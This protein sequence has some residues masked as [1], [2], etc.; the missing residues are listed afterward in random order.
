[1]R[2]L[3]YSRAKSNE[4]HLTVTAPRTIPAGTPL[5]FTVATA[6]LRDQA[7]PAQLAWRAF[8][9]AG[10]VLDRGR[11][12]STGTATV[13]L[14]A[15]LQVPQRIEV[16]AV[17]KGV[18]QSTTFE[19]LPSQ[20]APLVHVR[21]DKPVYRPGEVAWLRGVVLD[22]VTLKPTTQ[23]PRLQFSVLD[24]KGAEVAT[25]WAPDLGAEHGLVAAAQ[26]QV[27]AGA[28][29]GEYRLELRA[30]DRSFPS[31]G[32]PFLVRRFQ[33][34]QLA[35]DVALD[36]KTYAPGE[37]GVAEVTVSRL[38]GG[39]PA[40]AQ[41]RAAL[42]LD[43]TEVWSVDGQLDH[44]GRA[45]FHFQ[46]PEQVERGA[47]RFV[48]R[49]VDGGVV[50]TEVEPF[51]VPTGEVAAALYPESGELVVGIE[52]RV[53]V[54]VTD[55]LGRPV[56]A[57]GEVVDERGDQVA[58]FRSAHQGRGWFLLTPRTGRSYSL[59]LRQPGEH[60]FAIPSARQRG[61]VLRAL[62]NAVPGGSPLRVQAIS[63]VVVAIAVEQTD[64]LLTRIEA[65]AGAVAPRSSQLPSLTRELVGHA[66]DPE[67]IARAARAA[68]LDDVSPID[69]MRST[70]S[71]RRLVLRNVLR[72]LITEL[73]SP[74]PSPSLDE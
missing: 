1:M 22:R 3:W 45:L 52:S 59:R 47:A 43:G 72:T 74:S 49:I 36:R 31:E 32:I 69:D 51:V 62:A 11:V 19:L 61:A 73:T 7:R 34:P 21:T 6:D 41:V 5:G 25:L 63:K 46:V 66:P 50:E 12:Q 38:A 68:A 9:A 37:L 58:A 27:P 64:G 40:G 55:S 8:D 67:R 28:A 26:W 14:P 13:S 15:S 48:A 10:T 17:S 18:T 60:E 30:S 35:K 44:A 24:P 2:S 56:V 20:N 16:D 39:I 23:R 33:P 42:V 4:L 54:E 29:G 53:Y 71:Y 70:A 65:A 57:E